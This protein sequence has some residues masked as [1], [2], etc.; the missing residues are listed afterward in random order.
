MSPNGIIDYISEEMIRAGVSIVSGYALSNQIS[1]KLVKDIYISMR[2]EYYL[3]EH[4]RKPKNQAEKMKKELLNEL[5]SRAKR[6]KLTRA[7]NRYNEKREK[8]QI[9]M[10]KEM[11]LADID[12]ASVIAELRG[13]AK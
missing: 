8:A 10:L 9:N 4:K 11:D 1:E 6:A 7:I 3:N 2:A 12:L 5:S 13:N